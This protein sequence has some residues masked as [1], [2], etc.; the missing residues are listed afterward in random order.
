MIS[1]PL[2]NN[3]DLLNNDNAIPQNSNSVTIG[4]QNEQTSNIGRGTE[5]LD[6]NR[7]KKPFEHPQPGNNSLQLA[8][9]Y[10]VMNEHFIT[11][12]IKLDNQSCRNRKMIL[13]KDWLAVKHHSKNWYTL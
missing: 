1:I 6:P 4:L 12:A 13:N 2:Q 5:P 7:A 10:K 3:S 9:F 11:K 8:N